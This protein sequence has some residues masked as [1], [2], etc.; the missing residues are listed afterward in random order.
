MS[1]Y[2]SKLRRHISLI[3]TFFINSGEENKPKLASYQ[4]AD[5][6]KSMLARRFVFVLYVRILP[7][8]DENTFANFDEEASEDSWMNNNIVLGQI[9]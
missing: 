5:I 7:R 8:F 1:I 2:I 9:R 4:H 6:S 3:N